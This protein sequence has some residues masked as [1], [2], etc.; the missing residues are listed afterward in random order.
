MRAAASHTELFGYDTFG[1]GIWSMPFADL[2]LRKI[3]QHI[4]LNAKQ[5]NISTDPYRNNMDKSH[6]KNEICFFLQK[7]E[8]SIESRK[9]AFLNKR[10]FSLI[11]FVINLTI[12]YHYSSFSS[13]Q[14]EQ[15]RSKARYTPSPSRRY[16]AG[17]RRGSRWYFFRRYTPEPAKRRRP[18]VI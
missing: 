16:S 4:F 12:G 11:F 13:L 2:G 7:I 9:A 1:Q 6:R 17:R 14:R 15:E 18:R 10:H 8:P 3:R 5:M